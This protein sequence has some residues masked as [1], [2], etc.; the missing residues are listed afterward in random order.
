[1]YVCSQ[2]LEHGVSVMHEQEIGEAVFGRPRSYDTN[3]DNIVRVNATGLRKRLE[4]YYAEE[5]AAEEIVVEMPRGSYTPVFRRR[6]VV[7]AVTERR[8]NS[9][10][11][12]EEALVASVAQPEPKTWGRWFWPAVS[13]LLGI[14]SAW[15]AW[16]NWALD[17]QTERWKAEPAVQTLWGEFF[18]PGKET[19]VVL[20]DTSFA[21]AE[22]MMQRS[23]SLND[24]IN[25]NYKRLPAAANFSA[26]QQ[27]DLELVLERNNGSTGDFRA[28]Q[29]ILA[30][31]ADPRRAVLK[32][33]REYT[34]D[35]AKHNNLVLIGSQESNPWVGLFGD[36]LN[37]ALEYDPVARRPYVTNRKPQAG[38]Q[39][40]YSALDAGV[41]KG[42]EPAAVGYGV[43]AYMPGLSGNG[44]ALILEGTDSQATGATGEF[45][46]SEESLAAFESK[47]SGGKI[48]SFEI[49]IKTSQVNGTPLRS[50]VVAYRIYQVGVR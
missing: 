12:R 49:L 14:V 11:V 36:K 46:T 20:A 29:Q 28:A 21:L 27:R 42:P 9:L 43:I 24:Y 47:F 45:V 22:D 48:P 32:F 7:G 13:L 8:P 25:Y 6:S 16:Q 1:L 4:L 15:L 2:T 17:R 31:N 44:K 3:V 30:L 37:F 35:Q 23:I 50:E 41:T 39:G 34:A 5:G 19:H 26:D 18:V 33:A 10:S 38:E 40:V